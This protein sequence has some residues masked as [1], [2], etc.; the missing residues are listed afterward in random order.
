[1]SN[2]TMTKIS[3]EEIALQHNLTRTQES[4]GV[5]W[6]G[7]NFIEAGAE[8]TRFHLFADGPYKGT[9]YDHKIGKRYTSL[10]VAKAAG[11]RYED[12]EASE[13]DPKLRAAS[14]NGSSNGSSNGSL[15]GSNG[16]QPG[17]GNVLTPEGKY[18]N[19]SLE[20]RGLSPEA[21]RAF[22]I[23]GP[24]AK[25]TQWGERRDF[26][27][28]HPDGRVGRIRR[29][30]RYPQRQLETHPLAKP[31]KADWDNMTKDRG[32]PVGY[33]INLVREGETVWLVNSELAVWLFW[34]EGVR[35]V[36][37]LG[38]A[39]SEKSFEEMLFAVA[40]K[41]AMQL[42]VLLDNDTAGRTAAVRAWRVATR[43]E[44][45]CVVHDLSAGTKE[46]YDAADLWEYWRDYQA[47]E[48]S[49]ADL[50]KG[51]A[52]AQLAVLKVWEQGLKAV[53]AKAAKE[54]TDRKLGELGRVIESNRAGD[55]RKCPICGKFAVIADQHNGGWLCFDKLD[56]C[57]EHFEP[58][59]TAIAK[60]KVKA[61]S[62]D[63]SLALLEMLHS[64]QLFHTDDGSCCIVIDRKG[65]KST[66]D[67]GSTEFARWVRYT[68]HVETGKVVKGDTLK[69]AL[70]TLA[71]KAYHE[72][73]EMKSHVRTAWHNNKIYIDL[74]NDRSEVVEIDGDGWRILETCDVFFRRDHAMLELPRPERPEHG[75]NSRTWEEF[76]GLLNYGDESNWHL[77]MAWMITALYPARWPCPALNIHGEAGSAKSTLTKLI[78]QTLDPNVAM[79]MSVMIDQRETAI[80]AEKAR[81]FA[82]DNQESLE[83]WQSNLLAAMVTGQAMPF[84]KLFTDDDRKIFKAQPAMILNGIPEKIG[85]ADLSDRCLK[86][87]IPKLLDVGY[88]GEEEIWDAW[89]PI[90]PFILCAV[91]DAMSA[92]LKNLPRARDL[93]QGITRPRMADFYKW[94][95]CCCD[96]LP[97]TAEDFH[98]SYTQN[99]VESAGAELESFFA[100]VVLQFLHEQQGSWYGVAQDLFERL[101]ETACE[102][103]ADQVQIEQ[104]KKSQWSPLDKQAA[105]AKQRE[106]S[107]T[108]L[109][110]MSAFPNNAGA[111]STWLMKLSPALRKFANINCERLHRIAN[112][113]PWQIE[114]IVPDGEGKEA[115]GKEADE[116]T[117]ALPL[118]S[119]DNADPAVFDDPEETENNYGKD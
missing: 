119:L 21:A 63:I 29:K 46:G 3:I 50:L 71:S 25:E 116:E 17:P 102:R 52:V 77:I 24:V 118:D 94:V 7:R 76:K 99:I 107:E 106:K 23:S 81:I 82:L 117:P 105:L 16:T 22:A 97:M 11:V 111:M 47:S 87:F 35:A 89:E 19:R 95:V 110:R 90:R 96:A 101:W 62:E 13:S 109:R 78:R 53:E 56:G 113:V 31:R 48:I 98:G 37:T 61:P 15:N 68:Y 1:M 9:A 40:E 18:D 27:T 70:D 115:E 2:Q 72:G 42:R 5:V 34:Q 73:P 36:C 38:E 55:K 65:K 91:F 100:Q 103:L 45:D 84:R 59:D 64:F 8:H 67:I 58:E 44:I 86:L 33:G 57:G 10:Q 69:A 85:G 30:Y 20:E 28:F 80:N 43:L 39:R 51:T 112:G 79:V 6:V 92:G 108:A 54:V 4:E 75:D 104:I 93:I 12:Y 83:K 114:R 14:L 41:G 74:C 88:I 60:A 49:F 66:Y 32:M 26:P